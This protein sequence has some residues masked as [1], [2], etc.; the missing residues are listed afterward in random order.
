T[1]VRLVGYF[2]YTDKI[3]R[4]AFR[5]YR[6]SQTSGIFTPETGWNWLYPTMVYK[7]EYNHALSSSA[8]LEV[9][10]GGLYNLWDNDSYAPT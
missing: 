1:N 5:P 10:A 3:H 8:Y 6:V 4:P 7:G 9:I 2:N